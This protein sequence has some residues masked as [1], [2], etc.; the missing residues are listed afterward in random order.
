MNG[1]VL[2]CFSA[3][4]IKQML[5]KGCV[6]LI[7]LFYCHI[8]FTIHHLGLTMQLMQCVKHWCVYVIELMS[9]MVNSNGYSSEVVKMKQLKQGYI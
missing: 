1:T 5:S 6:I 3:W 8:Y 9:G 2:A 4:D 7:L